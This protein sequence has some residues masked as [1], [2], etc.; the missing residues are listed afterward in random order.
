MSERLSTVTAGVSPRRQA[1]PQSGTP[2]HWVAKDAA[3]VHELQ[4]HFV[5]AI[6]GGS[7]SVYADDP[8]GIAALSQDVP[9]MLEHLKTHEECTEAASYIRRVAE[10]MA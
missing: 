6:P 5:E 4:V 9:L 3:W 7:A 8:R 1:L 10:G 2:N